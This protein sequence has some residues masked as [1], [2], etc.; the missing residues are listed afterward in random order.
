MQ[1]FNISE[2]AFKRSYKLCFFVLLISIPGVFAITLLA[3]QVNIHR[4]LIACGATTIIFLLIMAIELPL[5]NRS[6]RKIKILVDDD[7]IIRKY[8]K[9]E[10]SFCW[11]DI[12]RVKMRK[13]PKGD[14]VFIKL[15]D[16]LDESIQL[17]A[18]EQMNEM[19]SLICEKISDNAIVDTKQ[20][21]F[22]YYELPFLTLVCIAVLIVNFFIR[23]AGEFAEDILAV[24]MA[25]AAGLF[26]WIYKPFSK[27]N[28]SL[29]SFEIILTILV[30][31][32]GICML[33]GMF[34]PD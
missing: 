26:L 34:M 32:G 29:K 28:P 20:H 5:I 4:L 7:K 14:Y 11:D 2:K 31:L 27:V 25:T 18:L 19:A 24:V 33:I 13:N 21:K 17:S 23:S 10:Q 15:Y 8:G 6:M 30:V 3:G 16:D 1:E 9:G 22:N 12:T